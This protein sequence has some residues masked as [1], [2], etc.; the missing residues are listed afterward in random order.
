MSTK[1][2]RAKYRME[3]IENDVKH[4]PY[5]VQQQF[6]TYLKAGDLEALEALPKSNAGYSIGK[7]A[8]SEMKQEEYKAVLGIVTIC[9]AS[10]EA[11]VDPQD[12]YDI[13]DLYLQK[14]S[15]V[16]RIEQYQA[17]LDEATHEIVEE[18]RKVK[19]KNAQSVH[20]EKC[21]RYIGAN[22]NRR[23]TQ[24]SIAKDL[25]LSP[26]YL[27]A[28]FSR[29]EHMTITEYI[30]RER[31]KA[32]QN[33]LKYSDEPIGIISNYF[34]FCSQSHFSAVFRRYTG[35]TPSEFRLKSMRDTE[36]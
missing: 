11:G 23:M 10:I 5:S 28:I 24:L 18:I 20:V 19:S 36:F 8:Y 29:Y 16:K 13:A 6:F 26:N 15:V 30:L 35:M 4:V 2:N 1:S 7:M 3:N 12:S 22:L 14:V 17:Y 33:L 31:I 25:E 27:S 21:K 34:C 9:Q 32:A